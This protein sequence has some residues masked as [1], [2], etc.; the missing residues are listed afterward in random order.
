MID[1]VQ[2]V[3]ILIREAVEHPWVFQ[4]SFLTQRAPQHMIISCVATHELSP[5]SLR[6]FHHWS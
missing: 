6:P 1:L 3:D 2:R 5:H 4:G